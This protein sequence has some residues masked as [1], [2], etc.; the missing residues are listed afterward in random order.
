MQRPDLVLEI[1]DLLRRSKE[2]A[3]PV[4]GADLRPIGEAAI[5]PSLEL[6]IELAAQ[7][8]IIPR[9]FSVDELLGPWHRL[10]G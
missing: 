10:T 7:Q 1:Y 8:E 2:A 4:R 3:G 9:R 5:S 6:V